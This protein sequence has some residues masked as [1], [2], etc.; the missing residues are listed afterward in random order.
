MQVPF[1]SILAG[2]IQPSLS[3]CTTEEEEQTDKVNDTNKT[4]TT[5]RRLVQEAGFVFCIDENYRT[6]FNFDYKRGNG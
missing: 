2:S 4:N 6:V 1:K 3:V 5:V